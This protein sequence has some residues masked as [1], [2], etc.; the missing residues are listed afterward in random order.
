MS[1]GLGD[2]VLFAKD[3]TIA[4]QAP[5]DIFFGAA[6]PSVEHLGDVVRE[7]DLGE[8]WSSLFKAVFGRSIAHA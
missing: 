2:H 1:I 6:C 4:K 8:L 3:R 7:L 5:P